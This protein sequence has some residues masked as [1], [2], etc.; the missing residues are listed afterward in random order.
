MGRKLAESQ[1]SKQV[2]IKIERIV[3]KILDYAFPENYVF[4]I[5]VIQIYLFIKCN[6]TIPKL[7]YI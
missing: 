3:L 5:V 4:I 6:K 1:G 2:K 7:I